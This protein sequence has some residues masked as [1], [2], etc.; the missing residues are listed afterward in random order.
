MGTGRR[1]KRRVTDAFLTVSDRNT[2][3]ALGHLVDLTVEG[4]KLRGDSPIEVDAI[5][6]LRL[7]LPSDMTRSNKIMID[8]KCVWSEKSE[9]GEA[10]FSGFMMNFV[11]PMDLEKIEK[12][13]ESPLFKYANERVKVSLSKKNLS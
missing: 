11:S 3:K 10:Y 4:L 13:L 1:L 5:F 6:Q 9:N 12:I 8:V 2:G 7:D